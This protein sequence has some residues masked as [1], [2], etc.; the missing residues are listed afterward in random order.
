MKALL[1]WDTA[2]WEVAGQVG[3]Q[4]D[5]QMDAV[6]RW[7]K[8]DSPS[9][10]SVSVLNTAFVCLLE[11]SFCL[12]DKRFITFLG[13]WGFFFCFFSLVFLGG[14][15]GVWFSLYW[16][17]VSSHLTGHFSYISRQESNTEGWVGR[18]P[19]RGRSC[20]WIVEFAFEQ[21]LALK[22]LQFSLL[23]R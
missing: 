4:T 22:R 9:P 11:A 23:K 17:S 3:G 2:A 13:F 10:R 8:K 6:V 14:W 5:R 15:A 21:S 19:G 12:L 16:A 1:K 7:Q 20:T 18:G